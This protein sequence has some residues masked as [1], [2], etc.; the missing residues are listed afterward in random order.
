M[1]RFALIV[2]FAERIFVPEPEKIRL[3]NVVVPVAEIVWFP[4]APRFTV[5]VPGVKRVAF[6]FQAFMLTE[7]SFSVLEP[8]FREPAVR[9]TIPVN[10][11]VRLLPRLRVPPFPFKVRAPPFT[12]PVSEA[13]PL[14]F[15]MVTVPVVVKAPIF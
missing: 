13:V 4:A 11:W 15:D 1:E 9:V 5:P 14:V 8:P 7:F 10:V 6:P 2:V 3:L 12:L